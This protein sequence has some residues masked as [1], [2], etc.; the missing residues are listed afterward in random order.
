MTLDDSLNGSQ[1]GNQN[2]RQKIP[3]CYICTSDI[4]KTV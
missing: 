4:I 2:V 1:G 3:I